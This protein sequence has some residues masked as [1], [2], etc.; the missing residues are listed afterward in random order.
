MG[1]NLN[2]GKSV[3]YTNIVLVGSLSRRAVEITDQTGLFLV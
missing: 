1:G 2:D 3:H